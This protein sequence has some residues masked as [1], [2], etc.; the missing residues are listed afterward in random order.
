MADLQ[1]KARRRFLT[2]LAA[3][4]VAIPFLRVGFAGAAAL[5]HLD[6]TAANAKALHYTD[7]FKTELKNPAHKAGAHCGDCMFYKGGTAQWGGCAIFP[8]NDVHIDGW[9]MSWTKKP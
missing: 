7:D 9:C 1:S 8:Q 5:P 3:A 4:G 6:P 2:N